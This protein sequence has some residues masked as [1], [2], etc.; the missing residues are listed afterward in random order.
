MGTL[1]TGR[2]VDSSPEMPGGKHLYLLASRDACVIAA[3]FSR[4]WRK[5]SSP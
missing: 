1:L 2:G 3:H 4:S 5:S